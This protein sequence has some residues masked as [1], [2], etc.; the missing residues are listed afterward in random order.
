VSRVLGQRLILGGTRRPGASYV[1]GDVQSFSNHDEQVFAPSVKTGVADRRARI[2]VVT[3]GN[4][5]GNPTG[6]R[7]SSCPKR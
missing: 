7:R 1:T 6:S 4:L 5:H 3:G 2:V